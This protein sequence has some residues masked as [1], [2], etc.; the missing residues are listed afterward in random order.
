MVDQ[1]VGEMVEMMAALSAG[2]MVVMLGSRLIGKMADMMVVLMA[3]HLV[4]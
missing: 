1:L 3:V 2:E 4:E